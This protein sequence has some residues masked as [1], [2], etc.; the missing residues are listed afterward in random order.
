MEINSPSGEDIRQRVGSLRLEPGN[1]VCADCGKEGKSI[2]WSFASIVHAAGE[3]P[4]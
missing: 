3:L 2:I 4:C 1:N